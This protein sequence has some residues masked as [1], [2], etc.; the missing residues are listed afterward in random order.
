M[1]DR[2]APTRIVAVAIQ[3]YG[4]IF[5]LPAPARHHNVLHAM[6][7]AGLDAGAGGPDA[8]GFL[9]K[10]GDFLGRIGAGE[11]AKRNGQIE[12]L[13]WPPYLYSEDLW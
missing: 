10:K 11:C 5:T 13:Q 6:D 4:L 3:A 12:K 2:D 7:A 9:T 1:T 8:Q